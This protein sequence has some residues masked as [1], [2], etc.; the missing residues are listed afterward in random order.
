MKR[1]ILLLAVFILAFSQVMAYKGEEDKVKGAQS[2]YELEIQKLELKMEKELKKARQRYINRVESIEEREC[3]VE[4]EQ[5]L[6]F[7]EKN[8]LERKISKIKRKYHNKIEKLEKKYLKSKAKDM[9]L[10]D[11][12]GKGG[13]QKNKGNERD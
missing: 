12:P 1:F 5:S 6:K 13:K 8:K 10:E 2:K 7:K 3:E 4:K 11:L 9:Q